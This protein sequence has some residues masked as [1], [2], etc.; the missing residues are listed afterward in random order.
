MGKVSLQDKE[1]FF[2]EVILNRDRFEARP[3]SAR[4]R[5]SATSI[6]CWPI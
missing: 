5:M 6:S 1:R 4:C 2:V 3:A